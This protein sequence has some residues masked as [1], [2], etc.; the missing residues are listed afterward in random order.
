MRGGGGRLLLVVLGVLL[1]I[2]LLLFRGRLGELGARLRLAFV[3]VATVL[4]VSLCVRSAL[5]QGL[6]WTAFA[7]LVLLPCVALAWRDLLAPRKPPPAR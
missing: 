5:G 7:L 2:A 1:A 6:P 4:L 3:L